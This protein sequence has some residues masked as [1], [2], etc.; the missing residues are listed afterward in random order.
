MKE[1][2]KPK[3]EVNLRKLMQK[4]GL[5]TNAFAEKCGMSSQSMSQ[6]LRN[7]SLTT[8]TIYRIATALD[9]DPRDMFFPTEEKND[10]FS[11]TETKQNEE[12][13]ETAEKPAYPVH[14]NGLVTENQ[15]QTEAMIPANNMMQTET[16]CPHCGKKV[17]VGVVLLGEC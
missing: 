9:I 5:G 1:N 11:N 8:T 16:F 10:L 13:A 15:Q 6:F 14:E 17:R 7:K 4:L 2:N 3:S 12:A